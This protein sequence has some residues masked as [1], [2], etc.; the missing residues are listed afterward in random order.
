M[1]WNDEIKAAIMRK[2]A[3]WKEVAASDE[4]QNERFG[5]KMNEVKMRM[6]RRGVSSLEDGRK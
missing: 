5:R 2:E 1:W 6:G 3:A 4:K